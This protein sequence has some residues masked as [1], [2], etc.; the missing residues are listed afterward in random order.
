MYLTS[1]GCNLYSI[2]S[3]RFKATKVGEDEEKFRSFFVYANKYIIVFYLSN[4]IHRISYCVLLV[5][6][7]YPAENK[8]SKHLELFSDE[9]TNVCSFYLKF[10]IYITLPGQCKTAI[11]C[12]TLTRG[13]NIFHLLT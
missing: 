1:T 8:K 2:I 13:S 5:L 10:C 11:G 3:S 4:L 7:I 6:D 9:N 12:L